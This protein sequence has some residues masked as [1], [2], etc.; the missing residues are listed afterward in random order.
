MSIRDGIL[1]ER[2]EARVIE[3]EARL[4]QNDCA[5]PMMMDMF[6]TIGEFEKRIAKLESDAAMMRHAIDVAVLPQ[7]PEPG[8]QPEPL[9]IGSVKT[10]NTHSQAVID[11]IKDPKPAKVKATRA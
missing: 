8:W 2:L 10:G 3:M 9:G 6:Q 4:D 7:S 1:V 5:S 11:A